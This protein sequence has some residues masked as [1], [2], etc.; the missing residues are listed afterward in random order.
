MDVSMDTKL[1]AKCK[2]QHTLSTR[3]CATRELVPREESPAR[4]FPSVAHHQGRPSGT[5]MTV[6]KR[7]ISSSPSCSINV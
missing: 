1:I 3:F 6:R 7:T 4:G 2:G 5:S